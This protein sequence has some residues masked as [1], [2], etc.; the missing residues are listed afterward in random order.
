MDSNDADAEPMLL[1]STVACWPQ[2][3]THRFIRQW[4]DGENVHTH[5]MSIFGDSILSASNKSTHMGREAHRK[6][7]EDQT[8]LIGQMV[9]LGASNGQKRK[10]EIASD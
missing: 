10:N 6:H 4:L 1:V 8:D 3:H 9:A 7:A 2:L 5:Q